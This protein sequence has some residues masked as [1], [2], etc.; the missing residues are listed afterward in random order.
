MAFE[1]P[2]TCDGR[3][4]CV[5]MR[6]ER[7]QPHVTRMERSKIISRNV[8]HLDRAADESLPTLHDAFRITPVCQPCRNSF[9]AGWLEALTRTKHHYVWERARNRT[10]AI[11]T[12][13]A[14][15]HLEL[16]CYELAEV[17]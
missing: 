15:V 14:R 5:R 7:N 3:S 12:E 16:A 9:D 11:Q 17:G 2:S 8:E 1:T 10:L 6:N 13:H 4:E